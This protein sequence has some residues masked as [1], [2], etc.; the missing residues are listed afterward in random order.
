VESCEL[1]STVIASKNLAVIREKTMEDTLD[2]K[3]NI[4]SFEPAE[5]IKVILIDPDN[6]GD[7]T[8]QIG[9]TLSPK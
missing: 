4:G 9:I 7:K 6:S 5:A 3:R 1:T 8:V 2:S